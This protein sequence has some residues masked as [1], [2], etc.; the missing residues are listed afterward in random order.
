MEP[1]EITA[2]AE[3]S[4]AGC[5]NER[6]RFLMQA[7]VR[8]V[9]AFVQEVGLTESE[10]RVAVDALT[11]TGRITNE[12][13]Q[14][15]ILW[16]DAL[17]VSMLVDA[18]AHPKPPGATEST[19]LGPFWVAD[20]PRRE[21]GEAIFDSAAG[22]PA[23]I[24]GHV[25]DLDGRPIGDA[26]LDVWQNDATLL[27][28][29]QDPEAPEAHLR[30]RFRTRPDGGYAFLGVRPVA[31]PIPDDGPVGAMLAATGRHPWRPAHIHV[32][33]SAP[34]YQTLTTHFFDADSDYLTSDAVFAVKPSLIRRFVE[35]G[36]EDDDRPPSVTGRWWSMENDIV[37]VGDGTGERTSSA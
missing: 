8:H 3:A 9:H 37:L 14:E 31:Y 21:Y 28:G 15:F 34:G 35:R 32:I 1:R 36:A 13:R 33:V 20:S 30:G 2:S 19:V 26:S 27:Y 23:W 12:Q 6:L 22:E 18:L 11:E 5:E 25:L 29:V 17:G 24:Q 4:F 16:S 10:W 7:L